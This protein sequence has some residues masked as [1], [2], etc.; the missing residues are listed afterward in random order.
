MSIGGV[1]A[2]QFQQPS[3]VAA[4]KSA[5]AEQSSAIGATVTS[6][7]VSIVNVSETQSGG[8]RRLVV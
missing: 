5:V 6:D 4:F 7:D 3:V 8:G 2:V 1:S